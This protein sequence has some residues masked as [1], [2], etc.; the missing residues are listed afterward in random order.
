MKSPV[1]SPVVT[2]PYG[3]RVLNG[4]KQF[5]PGIDYVSSMGDKNVYSILPG[6]C[7][8]DFDSYDDGKRWTDPIHSAGNYICIQHFLSDGSYFFA[9]Y[10]HLKTNNVKEGQLVNEGY[11]LGEYADVGLS[12]GAHLHIESFDSAWKPSDI[13]LIMGPAGIPIGH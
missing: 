1:D 7:I 4:Q 9:R 6:K 5:H 3:W 10:L 12:Y 13:G 11:C 2:S 8:L